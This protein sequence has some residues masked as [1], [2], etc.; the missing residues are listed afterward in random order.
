MVIWVRRDVCLAGLGVQL[1]G[2]LGVR[3]VHRQGQQPRGQL[4][5][6]PGQVL[7]LLAQ[8]VHLG[9]QHA[10]LRLGVGLLGA[11]V[12]GVRELRADRE[13]PGAGGQH[14]RRAES[15]GDPGALGLQCFH[16]EP[17]SWKRWVRS[18]SVRDRLIEKLPFAP[19][20][21]FEVGST[22]ISPGQCL[23]LQHIPGDVGHRP[24]RAGQLDAADRV[25][26]RGVERAAGGTLLA[27]GRRGAGRADRHVER[28][29]GHAAGQRGA[30]LADLGGQIDVGGHQFG[31]V[32]VD[33]VDGGLHLGHPGVLGLLGDQRLRALLLDR[34]VGGGRV[35]LQHVRSRTGRRAG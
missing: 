10:V 16:R 33:A 26:P 31:Q 30:D 7:T 2:Q 14:G 28:L 19:S 34:E 1:V 12:V 4:V 29:Q 18:W 5:G 3:R 13:E 24:G 9:L 27:A 15:A 6:Q 20:A 25:V 17:P 35:R 8:L 32:G 23:Q 11:H 21:A 22:S